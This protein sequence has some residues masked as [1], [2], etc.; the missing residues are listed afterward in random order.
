MKKILC[1]KVSATVV[2]ECGHCK[3][4]NQY[5]IKYDDDGSKIDYEGIIC[6]KCG[7][8]SVDELSFNINKVICDKPEECSYFFANGQQIKGESDEA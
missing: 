5:M 6:W 4:L 1:K 2:V 3:A 8:E 7:K